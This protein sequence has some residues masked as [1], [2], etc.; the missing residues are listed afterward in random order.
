MR[1]RCLVLEMLWLGSQVSVTVVTQR[2][3][4]DGRGAGLSCF[5]YEKL[6]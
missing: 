2:R 5:L 6:G 4:E 1:K 3:S